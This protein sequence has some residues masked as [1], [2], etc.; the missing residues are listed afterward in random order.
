MT[1]LGI[2]LVLCYSWQGE[3]VPGQ[4]EGENMCVCEVPLRVVTYLSLASSENRACVEVYCICAK[5][6]CQKN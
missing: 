1:S 6:V 2:A 3:I 5:L 4:K